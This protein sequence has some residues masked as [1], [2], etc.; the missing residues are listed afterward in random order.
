[1]QAII[2]E[3]MYG[4]L[5]SRI[6]SDHKMVIHGTVERSNTRYTEWAILASRLGARNQPCPPAA[7]WLVVRI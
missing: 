2:M 3:I 6:L 5:L 4:A 7:R 1:M